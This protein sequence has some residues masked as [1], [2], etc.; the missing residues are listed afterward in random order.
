[1]P[2]SGLTGPASESAEHALD[3]L[4]SESRLGRAIAKEG[5]PTGGGAIEAGDCICWWAW[6]WCGSCWPAAMAAANDLSAAL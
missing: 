3:T 5:C 2:A 6:E 1:M 4:E